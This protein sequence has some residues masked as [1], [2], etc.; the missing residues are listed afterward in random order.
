MVASASARLHASAGGVRCCHRRFGSMSCARGSQALGSGLQPLSFARR[1][2]FSFSRLFTRCSRSARVGLFAGV[3]GGRGPVSSVGTPRSPMGSKATIVCRF[4]PALGASPAI[5][6]SG[7]RVGV[8]VMGLPLHDVAA[9]QPDTPPHDLVV[10]LLERLH[11][12]RDVLERLAATLR[13]RRVWLA[14]RDALVHPKP[15]RL[16][17][18]LTPLLAAMV[19]AGEFV[20]LQRNPTAPVLDFAHGCQRRS[21][22]CA[23]AEKSGV[24]P[25]DC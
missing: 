3:G 24:C 15:N 2:S 9:I 21:G 23:V 4:P 17:D 8:R 22:G 7:Q 12:L 11:Q 13:P 25:P 19:F 14:F 20:C 5:R 6:P 1:R 18:L 16:A 10:G